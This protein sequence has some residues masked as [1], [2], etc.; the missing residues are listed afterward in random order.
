MAHCAL[1]QGRFRAL[2]GAG[3]ERPEGGSRAEAIFGRIFAVKESGIMTIRGYE[4]KR[5]F[6]FVLF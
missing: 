2:M 3:L 5:V 1:D 6:C 4:A